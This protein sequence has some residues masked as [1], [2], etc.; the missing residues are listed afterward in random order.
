MKDFVGQDV[1]VGDKIFYSTTGRY[2]ECRYGEV[3]RFTPKCVVIKLL[4]GDRGWLKKLGEE[5][6]VSTSFVK[7][8][9]PSAKA[10]TDFTYI[11]DYLSEGD[12]EHLEEEI[13][14]VSMALKG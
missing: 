13:A 8:N 1:A 6:L 14:T 5:V 9:P 4:K 12:L 10:S 7:V 11:V 2:S 3:V